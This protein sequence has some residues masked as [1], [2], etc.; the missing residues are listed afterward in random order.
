MKRQIYI[1]SCDWCGERI[2]AHEGGAILENK[3]EID[4]CDRCLDH[5]SF[6]QGLARGVAISGE[7][8]QEVMRNWLKKYE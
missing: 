6:S 7:K 8:A 4:L 2:N 1:F 3:Q 5:L